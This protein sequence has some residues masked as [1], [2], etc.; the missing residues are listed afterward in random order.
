MNADGHRAKANEIK[1]SLERLLP[2]KE[3]QHVVAIV[4][5]SYGLLQH[6]ISYGMELKY[7]RHLN[8]H[9]GVCKEL[10]DLGEDHIAEIFESLDTLRAGRWYGGK[11]DGNVVN[12]CLEY[13]KEVEEWTQ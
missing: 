1:G 4:E 7:G 10:R 9:V 8:S 3:G 2:D 12:K 5:L 6:L 11:G 13:I